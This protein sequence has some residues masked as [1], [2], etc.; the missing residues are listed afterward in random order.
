MPP[1]STSAPNSASGTDLILAPDSWARPLDWLPVLS[2][3]IAAVA[4]ERAVT[5]YLDGRAA[6]VESATLRAIVTRACDYLSEGVEFASVVLLDG[7]VDV[8]A[9]AEPLGEPA[10]LAERLSLPLPLPVLGEDPVEI[11]RRATWAKALVDAIQA[12][13]DK[14]AFE[15]APRVPLEGMPLVTVRIPTYGSADLL[16]DRAI[17]SV[18]SGVYPNVEVL[19]CSDGPQPHARAAVEAVGDRRV[20]YLELEQRPVYPSRPSAFWQTAGTY[21]TNRLLDEARGALIAP[22][23]HDDAFTDDHIHL[24]LEVLRQGAGDFAFGQA[25]TEDRNGA[26]HLLGRAPLTHGYIVHASVMY[27]RRLAHMR[28]DPHAWLR[29]EP[30]DWN[31]WRRMRDTG[32]VIHHLPRP[33][34]VHFKE[35]SS[36]ADREPD[37]GALAQATAA[38]ILGTSARELLTVFA[39]PRRARAP[40]PAPTAAPV[41]VPT[42][43]P[44]RT[45]TRPGSTS[46]AAPHEGG[47]REFG[48]SRTPNGIGASQFHGLALLD[49]HFP[50]ELSGFR[51]HEAKAMLALVPEMAFFSAAP[52]GESWTRPVHPLADFPLLAGGLGITDVYCVFLNFTVSLLGLQGH[53]G[54]AT[55]GGIP[56]D[57][58]IGRVLRE[59]G[60]RL[61]STLYPGGGLV[62]GTDPELLRAVAARCETVFTNASEVEAAVTKAIRMPGPMATDF[63]TFEP[64][65]RR[66][67]FRLVFAADNRPRKGLDTALAAHALLD[68]RFHLDIAGPN[69]GYLKGVQQDRITFHGILEPARLRELY[70]TADAF[71]SPVRPE[72][73]DGRPGEVGLIDGFP[74]STA[75]EALASGCALISSN[76]RGDDWILTAG[77]HYLE[78]GMDDPVALAEAIDLLERDRNLRDSIAERGA[79]RIRAAMDVR[80]V[81]RAK[82]DAMGI[83]AHNV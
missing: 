58:G 76:P 39:R 67:P 1:D 8:P 11:V 12:D 51:W 77:R 60:I 50:L 3:Y 80:T 64:R 17:P 24:L 29:E 37:Q 63:Y 57:M 40:T 75:C 25:M 42:P 46:G 26:W 18:L 68:G 74:T 43:T 59:R 82:L 69:E 33:V 70:W 21:A 71:V 22:L 83:V 7:T 6:D 32:A 55:C 28:Y 65:P 49:T 52:T 4:P 56:P 62:T 41:P 79:A 34:A 54:A 20:R 72:G 35:G 38:D 19:V 30:G 78:V 53:P 15:A 31:L 45:S 14:A 36:V 16:V 13:L 27:S 2:A 9:G 23:D 81:T 66:Q 44:V 10:E 5:L 47:K 61:H 48:A 73:P